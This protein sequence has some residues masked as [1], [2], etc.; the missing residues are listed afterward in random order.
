MIHATSLHFRSW[1]RLDLRSAPCT[2]VWQSGTLDISISRASQ[3]TTAHAVVLILAS[4]PFICPPV[5]IGHIPH[6]AYLLHEYLCSVSYSCSCVQCISSARI[7]SLC[8]MCLSP[9]IC[10]DATQIS[11]KTS[12]DA[13]EQYYSVAC[14]QHPKLGIQSVALLRHDLY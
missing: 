2:P 14:G 9:F 4:S 5:S 13:V 8:L 6:V 3:P 12:F 1:P 11:G 7:R 10:R